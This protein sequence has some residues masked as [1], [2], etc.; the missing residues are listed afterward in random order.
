MSSLSKKLRFGLIGCGR[1]SKQ[2]V[3]SMQKLSQVE[4]K[5][6]C[7]LIPQ[8]ARQY[9]VDWTTDYRQLIKRDDIDIVS[10]C[11]PNGLHA[12]MGITIAQAGKHCLM[13][14]P[15]AINLQQADQM[16][17][18]FKKARKKLFVVKQVRFNPPVIALKNALTQQKLGKIYN[19]TLIMRWCRPQEYYDNDS[20]RGTKKLDGGALLNQ[21]IHY[22]DLLQWFLGPVKSVYAQTDKLAHKIEIEDFCLAILKFKSGAYGLIEFTVCAFP[23]NLECSIAILGSKGSVKLGGLAANE[24]HTWQV[25]NIPQPKLASSLAPNV[26]AG[27]LYQGSCPNHI[28]VYQNIIDCFQKKTTII[29]NGQEARKSLEIVEVIYKS[30]KQ[31]KEIKLPLKFKNRE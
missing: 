20:W 30:S 24:I 3:A 12:Q 31:N 7:D 5:A 1:I 6:V 29:T 15:L 18:A 21:G 26:Y 8:R 23:C 27:G 17:A 22:I 19:A 13:E 25:A 28:Y 4:L 14:K 2:H 10:V 11:T 9:K 16:L